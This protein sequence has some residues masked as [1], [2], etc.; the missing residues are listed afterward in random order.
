M[1]DAL[2][3][4][5]D[6]NDVVLM[7]GTR[8]EAQE[9]GL[10]HRIVRVMLI[11][12]TGKLLLQK[13]A[14]GVLSP[15]C[16]DFSSSGHVDAGEGYDEAACRE[17]SEEL[18]VREVKLTKVNYGKVERKSDDGLLFRRFFTAYTAHIPH[19][20]PLQLDYEE[21]EEVC[22]VTIDDLKQRIAENPD[23]YTHGLRAAVEWGEF[24]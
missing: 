23:N 22:W 18:S 16:W 19:D 7:S 1:T 21:V 17:L 12:E 20:Y 15:G 24:E 14:K 5:V 10:W 9:K 8:R 4:I 3:Q 6:E 2:I 11:D 13:R